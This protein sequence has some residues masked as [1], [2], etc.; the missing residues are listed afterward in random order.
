MPDQIQ[1]AMDRYRN[2]PEFKALVD[3]MT[4][5]IMRCKYTPSEMREA[6]ILASINYE[7]YHHQER[8][9]HQC[10][11][12]TILYGNTCM[13]CEKEKKHNVTG[14]KLPTIPEK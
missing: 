14:A 4:H 8:I 5:Q 12:G 6:S 13:Q 7:S 11:H 9:Y 3:M 2:D 1:S 10:K